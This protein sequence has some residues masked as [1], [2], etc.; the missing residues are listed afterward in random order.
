M[1]PVKGPG[2]PAHFAGCG[3]GKMTWFFESIAA[4]SVS[5]VRL[6]IHRVST[7]LLEPTTPVAM[8]AR[9]VVCSPFNRHDRAQRKVAHAHCTT[10]DS[11]FL[12]VGGNEDAGLGVRQWASTCE[13]CVLKTQ[14]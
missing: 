6:S 1:N 9:R 3:G 5:E 2:A 14:R 13:I 4:A 10:G 8:V 7:L 11:L 12:S